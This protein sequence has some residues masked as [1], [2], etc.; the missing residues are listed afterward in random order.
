M[1][2]IEKFAAETMGIKLFPAQIKVIKAFAEGKTIRPVR[3]M[4]LTKANQVI[5]EYIKAGL[6]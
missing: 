5:R 6:K 1:T 4:G 3:A 2:Q